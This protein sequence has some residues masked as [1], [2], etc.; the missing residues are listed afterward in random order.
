MAS[1]SSCSHI[2]IIIIILVFF[3]LPDDPAQTIRKLFALIRQI[4]RRDKLYKWFN[5][6][7]LLMHPS[8]VLVTAKRR[9]FHYCSFSTPA[10]QQWAHRLDLSVTSTSIHFISRAT[11]FARARTCT[12]YSIQTLSLSLF[13][14]G[15]LPICSFQNAPI[16]FISGFSAPAVSN[17]KHNEKKKT[18]LTHPFKTHDLIIKILITLL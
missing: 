13:L 8:L 5:I 3:L 2:I 18:N 17:P 7:N 6:W 12:L 4:C 10:A 15:C 11:V 16:S 1:A 14:S 9:G